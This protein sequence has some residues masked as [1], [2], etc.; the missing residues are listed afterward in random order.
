MKPLIGSLTLLSTLALAACDAAG[1]VAPAAS[2]DLSAASSGASA[3]ITGS[4][5][6]SRTVGGVEDLTTFSFTAV[7]H[8][9]GSVSGHYK[10]TFRA[11]NFAIHGK[12]T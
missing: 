7:R 3:V 1:P 8:A 6:H 9:D 5:H 11:N 10:Y 4:G 2:P 12:V